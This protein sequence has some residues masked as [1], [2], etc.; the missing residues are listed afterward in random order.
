MILLCFRKGI[1]KSLNP[2]ERTFSFKKLK[3]FI[4]FLLGVTFLDP[5]F[6]FQLGFRIWIRMAQL[7]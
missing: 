5:D 3:F 4:F 7:N 6:R 2:P 1:L